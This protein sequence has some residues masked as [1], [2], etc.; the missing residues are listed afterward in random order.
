MEI[1]DSGIDESEQRPDRLRE[2]WVRCL[3]SREK[4]VRATVIWRNKELCASD[5]DHESDIFG[6]R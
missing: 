5:H 1:I 6:L 3:W 4:R 2:E